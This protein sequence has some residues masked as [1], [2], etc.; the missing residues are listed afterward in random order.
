MGVWV[1]NADNETMKEVTGITG[2]A[3]IW[4]DDGGGTQRAAGPD[5][6]TPMAGGCVRAVRSCPT[7]LPAWI[8]E[9]FIAETELDTVCQMHQRIDGVVYTVLPPEAQ[10]WARERNLP[11]P[12]TPNSQPTTP[13]RI[14]SP[15][16]GAV[17]RIDPAQSRDM[18]RIA[19]SI[20]VDI[21]FE[22]IKLSVDNLP[23]A[24]LIAPPYTHLWVLEPGIY[25][26]SAIG[27]TLDGMEIVSEGVT[28]DV[29][30]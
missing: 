17:Y 23:L 22:Q 4:H 30:E 7:G 24:T 19:I 9:T 18:Q 1:G 21:H 10:A 25:T 11:Q 26:F 13:L 15:D 5:I 27:L 2:A 8:I 12:S 14:I 16:A 29:R 20:V 3:P 28:I 6:Y